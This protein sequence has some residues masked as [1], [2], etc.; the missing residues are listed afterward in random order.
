MSKYLA[1]ILFLILLLNNSLGAVETPQKNLRESQ[2]TLEFMSYKDKYGTGGGVAAQ[3]KYFF[4]E[5]FSLAFLMG[6]G[7]SWDSPVPFF[8]G[9]KLYWTPFETKKDSL[10]PYF[11]VGFA[12]AFVGDATKYTLPGYDSNVG[13]LI[14]GLEGAFWIFNAHAEVASLGINERFGNKD[15]LLV[16]LAIGLGSFTF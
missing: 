7:G 3:H 1:G 15:A 2:L 13:M 8:L 9:S 6:L 16:S 10:Y 11:G 4:N 5:N 14:F 12:K